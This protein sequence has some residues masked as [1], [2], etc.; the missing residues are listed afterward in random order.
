MSE[1]LFGTEQ[2]LRK[3]LLPNEDKMLCPPRTNLWPVELSGGAGQATGVMRT[4]RGP[5]IWLHFQMHIDA[6]SNSYC[7]LN[8][9]IGA[10]KERA[11]L[12]EWEQERNSGQKGRQSHTLPAEGVASGSLMQT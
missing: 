2:G 5:R 3:C 8:G 9:G 4:G 7:A 6:C 11:H 12:S 1:E 10:S